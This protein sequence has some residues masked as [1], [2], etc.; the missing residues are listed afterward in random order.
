MVFIIEKA[1]APKIADHQLLTS[2][3]DSTAAAILI[4][5]PLIT[6]VNSPKVKRLIGNV[7]KIRTGQINV[8]T[9]PIAKAAKTAAQKPLTLNPGINFAVKRIPQAEIAQ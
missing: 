8:F 1:I 7:K 4:T 5:A 2:N 9:R 3:P 6:N